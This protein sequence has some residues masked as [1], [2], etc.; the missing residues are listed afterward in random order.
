MWKILPQT[1]RESGRFILQ[2]RKENFYVFKRFSRKIRTALFLSV[3]LG[4]L[5]AA[6]CRQP[7]TEMLA[8]APADTLIYLEFNDLGEIF[9]TLSQSR[10]FQDGD[11]N[12]DFSIFENTQAAIAVSGFETSEKK[13]DGETS[14]LDF[15]PQFVVIADTHSWQRTNLLL[16]ENQISAFV[17][18][19]FGGDAA[20]AK[21]AKDDFEIF[22]WTAQDGR[23]F[24][25]AVGGSLIYL[26]NSE[27]ALDKCLKVKT[28]KAGNLLQNENL[29]QLRDRVKERLAFGFVS[30]EG[31]ARIADFAGVS[32]AIGAAEEDLTKSF[33]AGILPLIVQKSV[34][35]ISWIARRNKQGIE[36]KIYLKTDS[37]IA[38]I[39]KETLV[40]TGGKRFQTAEFLPLSFESA[41]RYDLQN[42]QIGWRSVLLALAKKLDAVDG[43]VWLAASGSFF[44]P[45]GIADAETFLSATDSEILTARLKAGSD[46]SIVIA[47]IRDESK[48]KSAM[49]EEFDFKA[50]PEKIGQ[51]TLWKSAESEMVSAFVENKVVIGNRKDVLNCL[52]AGESGKN[53]TK[54][55]QYQSFLQ[56]NAATTTIAKDAESAAK[57]AEVLN[58]S[59]G[60]KDLST[61]Y[62]TETRFNSD[63]IER[64][65]VSDFG[66]IGTLL[67]KIAA[68]PQ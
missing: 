32:T 66:F 38:D 43:K 8:F 27:T 50:A 3:A 44:A 34:K 15:K 65:T 21:S 68:S 11:K 54:T 46:E 61:F 45:Y 13:L 19:T 40:S 59:P 2:K 14:I 12:F 63:G 25:V 31:I 53:F 60:K 67:E 64:R 10:A 41:T 4:C 17:Q 49:L 28:Q 20:P 35:E 23:R 47:G 1:K 62:I 39:W 22:S 16:V 24:F 52:E 18:K 55:I 5:F 51:A 42:P 36:D 57:I 6:A 58:I 30:T 9:K 56:S 7:P 26:A 37:Q 29:R 33:I 48:I